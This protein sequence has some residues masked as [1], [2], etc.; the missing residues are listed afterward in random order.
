MINL[1]HL[2]KK[3]SLLLLLVPKLKLLIGPSTKNIWY[4]P[5]HAN[6]LEIM[7]NLKIYLFSSLISQ[8]VLKSRI[9]IQFWE[10][11]LLVGCSGISMS[12][13][14][15]IPTYTAFRIVWRRFSVCWCCYLNQELPPLLIHRNALKA[16]YC[17]IQ[18]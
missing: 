15:F 2:S 9:Q 6:L 10:V 12:L 11:L 8:S 5:S 16:K 18:R 14:F 1:L 13:E 17:I 3:I 4:N 7:N